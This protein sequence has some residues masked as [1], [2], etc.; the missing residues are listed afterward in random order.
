MINT[1][2]AFI[3]SIVVSY[4][5]GSIPTAYL[6][7]RAFKSVDIREIGSHNMGAMNVFYSIGFWPGM[8]VLAVDIIKGMLAIYFTY[9]TGLLFGIAGNLLIPME[10]VSGV[11]VIAG[12]NFPIFLKFRG[13][14]GGA[15]SIGVLA[16][17][18]PWLIWANAGSVQIP[19]PVAWLIYLGSFLLIMLVTRWPTIS[20]ALSFLVFPIVAGVVYKDNGLVIYCICIILVPVLMYIPRIKQ[21]YNSYGGNIKRGIFRKNLQD[22]K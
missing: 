15:T 6:V 5:L 17:L 2:L 10:M 8:L 13:G 11:A 7:G 1:I 21:I 19:V 9:L 20:Y 16:F 18:V 12:H 14:K 4:L 22:R 3:V